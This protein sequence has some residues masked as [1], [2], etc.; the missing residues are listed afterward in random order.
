VIEWGPGIYGCEAAGEHYFHVSA[1]R[2]KREQAVELASILP[3]PIKRK[4]GHLG[5]YDRVISER[6]SQM[7]W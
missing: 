2:L 3:N 1:R 5:E 6:M 7:G 4:P